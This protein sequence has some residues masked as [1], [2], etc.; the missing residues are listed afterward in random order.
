MGPRYPADTRLVNEIDALS[1][2]EFDAE[3]LLDLPDLR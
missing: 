3:N 2:E 1:V